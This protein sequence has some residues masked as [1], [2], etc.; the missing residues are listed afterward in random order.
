M[1]YFKILRTG[2]LQMNVLNMLVNFQN[3]KCHIQAR[4]L[5]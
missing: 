4:N 5:G 3:N 2:Y 1:A